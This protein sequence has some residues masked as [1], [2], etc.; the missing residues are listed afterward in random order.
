[1]C[2]NVGDWVMTLGQTPHHRPPDTH[3]SRGEITGRMLA[4]LHIHLPPWVKMKAPHIG[5]RARVRQSADRSGA[6]KRGCSG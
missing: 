1:M 5:T 4:T 3:S 6:G 2:D